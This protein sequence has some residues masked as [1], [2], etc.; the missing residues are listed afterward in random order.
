M[1][2]GLARTVDVVGTPNPDPGDRSEYHQLATSLGAQQIRQHREHVHL[3]DEI[4]LQYRH[5]RGR[6][7][8]RGGLVTQHAEGE[9]GDPDAPV[10]GCHLL[11]Q[12]LMTAEIV[13]IEFHGVHR[14]G[15]GATQLCAFGREIGAASRREDHVST[16]ADPPHHFQAYF[17]TPAEQHDHTVVDIPHNHGAQCAT[18]RRRPRDTDHPR[19]VRRAHPHPYRGNT[20]CYRRVMTSTAAE[21]VDLSASASEFVT[22]RH[23][24]TLTTL[25]ADGTPHVVAIGFTWDP[26]AGI[27]RVITDGSSIKAR[28]VRRSGYAALSQVDGPRW[29]TLEGP[30]E[31][32]TEPERVAEAEHRYARRYRT[33]RENPT[34]VV[35]AV[36]ATR[37]L[38]SSTLRG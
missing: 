28:N 37:V 8:F 22:E 24:A 13:G 31:V 12:R 3:G 23:L 33:P 27:A 29:L 17:T 2:S 25:R 36:R 26:E 9:D 14:A 7:P 21:R 6:V 5:R 20:D 18:A 10:F 30:A 34:R 16:G 38:S 11:Q 32:W 19:P 1:Q 15:A 35:I 4:G